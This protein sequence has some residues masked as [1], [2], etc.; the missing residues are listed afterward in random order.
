MG[1]ITFRVAFADTW[2]SVN[3][4]GKKIFFMKRIIWLGALLPALFISS[5]N[6]GAAL[7][8]APVWSGELDVAGTAKLSIVFNFSE[9]SVGNFHVAMDSPDQGAYGIKG[10]V[11]YLSTDSIDVSV[12]Q[13]YVRYKA[14]VGSQAADGVFQQGIMAL[15]LRITPGVEKA[16]RPQT[17]Q[18]PF[19]YATEEVTFENPSG[20]SRLSGTLT[21]PQAG[22]AETPVVLLVSGSGLQNRDEE[23]FGHKPFAVLADYLARNGVAS[24]RYDDRGFGQSTGDVTKATTRDF[25]SDAEA[26]LQ[27]LKADGRFG[28]VGVI[29]H[30]EGASIAFIL[31]GMEIKPDF[32]I[33]IGTPA[34]NGEIILESQLRDKGGE[35]AAREGM[36]QVRAANNPWMNY[37]LE[38]DPA[39]DIK[40]ADVP[41][42][43][44]YGE[45]DRQVSPLLNLWKFRRLQPRATVKVYPGLNHL[46]QHAETGAPEEYARI[47]ETFA[48]EVMDDIVIFIKSLE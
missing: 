1:E 18:P 5:V 11:N 20:A 28:R 15:P 40:A 14:S 39:D 10:K 12:P 32:V 38:Y 6:S 35:E 31:A 30:S 9:D 27:F 4:V 3:F 29:G 34:V 46:M 41:V 13:L 19:P 47:E 2:K 45:K 17:P 48:P 7:P 24:L 26:G 44:I 42:F 8:L 16:E 25:A 22:S 23:L 37:F 43:A 21:L 36:R 33:G